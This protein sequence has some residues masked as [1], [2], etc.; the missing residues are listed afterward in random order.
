M[1]IYYVNSRG[2]KIDL[3]KK[4]YRVVD[5]DVFDSRWD[6]VANGYEKKIEIDVF[7]DQAN[8]ISNMNYLYDVFAYDAENGLL[9]KL[10][11]NDTYLPCNV[12]NTKKTGWKGHIYSIVTFTFSAPSLA[13]ISEETKN[14][15]MRAVDEDYGKK[16]PYDYPLDYAPPEVGKVLWD[17]DHIKESEFSMI[18]NGAVD[19]PEITINGYKYRVFTTIQEGEYIIIDSQT[20]SIIKHLIDGTELNIFDER[21]V[22]NSVFKKIAPGTNMIEWSGAF[23][24]VMHVYKERREPRWM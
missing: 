17:I 2:Q 13:W 14:F 15:M 16:Y 8:F 1:K 6:T 19:D 11:V 21:D 12:L 23:S 10:Y 22:E 20:K 7:D 4:P 18:I 9:G 5:T 3:L 24:F